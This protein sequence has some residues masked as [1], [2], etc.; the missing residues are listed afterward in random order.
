MS[1]E[2]YNISLLDGQNTLTIL[3]G[4]A[5]PNFE[6]RK[7]I[8]ISGA[9]GVPFSHL[10]KNSITIISDDRFSIDL[11]CDNTIGQSYLLVDREKMQISFVE[12]AGTEYESRYI[13][14]LS[15]SK[16]FKIWNINTDESL[17]P[18][19]LAEKIKMS[20]SFFE[21]KT[22]AMRLVSTLMNFEANVHK[23]VE[24]KADERANR[25][26]LIAQTVTTNLPEAFKLKL[27]VF[28]G[29]DAFVFEVEIGIDPIDLSCRLISP[30]V[31]DFVIGFK[32][33][34]ID[35]QIAAIKELHENLRIF[36]I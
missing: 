29:E 7:P 5:R 32:N 9:I 21:S 30:E 35:K 26:V 3:H 18:L 20:R 24:A 33:E 15:F 31:N 2:K 19:R 17:T 27:P 10:E 8:L 11:D 22:E 4:E 28:K 23:E 36:E 25:K 16:D 13:G 34:I 14:Q 12:N 1:E 6:I